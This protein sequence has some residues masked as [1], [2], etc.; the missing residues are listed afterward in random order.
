V[1]RRARVLVLIAMLTALAGCSLAAGP[2]SASPVSDEQLA[3][4]RTGGWWRPQLN[5]C[6]YESPSIPIR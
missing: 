3:C 6:E 2:P 5:F 4:E 1:V